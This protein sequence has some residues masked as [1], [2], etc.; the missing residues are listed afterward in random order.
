MSL[1]LRP[2]YKGLPLKE[3]VGQLDGKVF[4]LECMWQCEEGEK[5]PGEYAMGPQSIDA[6]EVFE[7]A[8]IAWIASGDVEIT[9]KEL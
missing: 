4:D 5:Y 1:K 3:K 7:Q 9:D 6:K 2:T 8:N